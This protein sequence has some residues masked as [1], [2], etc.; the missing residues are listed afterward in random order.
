MFSFHSGNRYLHANTVSGNCLVCPARCSQGMMTACDQM[1][2]ARDNPKISQG[3][4]RAPL[5]LL[6]RGRQGVG[7]ML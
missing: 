4:R 7:S 5:V 6:C 1:F 2:R 3:C